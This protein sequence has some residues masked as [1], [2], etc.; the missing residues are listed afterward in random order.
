MNI[1]VIFTNTDF[2]CPMFAPLDFP[3]NCGSSS[4]MLMFVLVSRSFV[5]GALTRAPH[6][7][8]NVRSSE[9]NRK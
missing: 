9:V 2:D 1:S 3:G 8:I 6:R 4:S 7:N 5:G